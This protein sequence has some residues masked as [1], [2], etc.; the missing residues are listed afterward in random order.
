MSDPEQLAQGEAQDAVPELPLGPSILGSQV[1][2]AIHNATHSPKHSPQISHH[3]PT[4]LRN[5][6]SHVDVGFFDPEGV[7]ELRRTMSRV[8]GVVA[9]TTPKPEPAASS[10]SDATLD[11]S[12]DFEKVLRDVMRQ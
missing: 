9:P 11:G 5:N 6:S 7:G 10:L 1:N 8:S 12:F 3:H 2:A 4:H